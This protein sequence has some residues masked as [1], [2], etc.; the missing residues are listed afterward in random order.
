RLGPLVTALVYVGEVPELAQLSIVSAIRTPVAARPQVVPI[1]GSKADNA[2]VL[3]SLGL[4]KLKMPERGVRVA[5]IDS[6]FRGYQEFLR[7]KQ[8]PPSTKYIDLTAE[9]N[10]DILPDPFPGD[11]KEIGHGTRCA[12]ALA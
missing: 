7:K 8:L 2:R 10:R 6:D 12:L 5:I 4:E 9:R 11:P 1:K 3:R